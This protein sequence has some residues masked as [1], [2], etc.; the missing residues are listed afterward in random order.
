[1]IFGFITCTGFILTGTGTYRFYLF[2]DLEPPLSAQPVSY[3]HFLPTLF[4]YPFYYLVNCHKKIV[5]DPGL[6]GNGYMVYHHFHAC[7]GQ[8]HKNRSDQKNIRISDIFILR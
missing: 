7:H 4:Y 1:M 3:R 8:D 6:Y 2:A 5:P